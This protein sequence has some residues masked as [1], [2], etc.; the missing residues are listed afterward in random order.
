[1]NKKTIKSAFE[2]MMFVWGEPLKAKDVKK[3]INCLSAGKIRTVSRFGNFSSKEKPTDSTFSKRTVKISQ[4]E[5]AP[6]G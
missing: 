6:P 4:A 5:S 1:M 2:S 3:G